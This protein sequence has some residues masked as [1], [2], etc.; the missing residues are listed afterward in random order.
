MLIDAVKLPTPY[1]SESIIKGDSKSI[2]I[3]AA[4]VVAKV[5]RDRL[6]KAYD[7]QFPDYGFAKNMGYGTKEHLRAI[8]EKGISPIHRRSFAPVKDYLIDNRR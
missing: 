1:P 2:S 5:E 4:S 3:A 6:M 7:K 8:E